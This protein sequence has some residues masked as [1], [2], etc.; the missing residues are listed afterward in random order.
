MMDWNVLIYLLGLAAMEI[1][2][3]ID[4]IVFLSIVTGRLPAE[5]QPRARQLGLGLALGMRL[6]LLL[7]LSWI[8]A[9]DEPIFRLSDLGVPQRL[10]RVESAEPASEHALEAGHWFDD[11]VSW[12]D[13]ILLVGG[14]FLIGKSVHEIH[15]KMEGDDKHREASAP[16]SFVGVLA[17]VAILDMVF[18]LDSVI[19][20]VGMVPPKLLWVMA[21]AIILAV[22]VML[23][24][25]GP[26]S[27]FVSRHPTVKMLAL[28]FLILIGVMLVAESVG[29]HI[30]K[31]YIYFAMC[32]ALVVELLNLRVRPRQ[33]DAAVAAST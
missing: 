7:M 9:M 18:S 13:L 32:F 12:K 20:A 33:A 26:V 5:Q 27:A 3:G 19:T 17:Q 25:A 2:L 15:V 24:F 10:L 14:L 31:G 4:N 1:V 29:T 11:G 16:A 23:V 6:L 28:S 30:E 22:I 8:L 21:T